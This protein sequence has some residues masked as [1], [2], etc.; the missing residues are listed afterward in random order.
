MTIRQFAAR[1]R[2][3]WYQTEKRTRNSAHTET[4]QQGR[5][6]QQCALPGGLESSRKPQRAACVACMVSSS[7]E[8]NS[9]DA[10][11]SGLAGPGEP[12]LKKAS[13]ISNE[14]SWQCLCSSAPDEWDEL[15]RVNMCGGEL[16]GSSWDGG[17]DACHGSGG[18]LAGR[19]GSACSS[20][21]YGTDHIGWADCV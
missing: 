3:A 14:S 18:P 12:E 13:R 15:D 11:L 9:G 16:C 20:G 6:P 21:A 1:G 17:S 4:L 10:A 7:N 8:I 2:S 19:A 5:S